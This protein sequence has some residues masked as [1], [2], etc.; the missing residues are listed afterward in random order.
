MDLFLEELNNGIALNDYCVTLNDMIF[1]V[2][3]GFIPLCDSF[4]F[5]NNC[6][7]ELFNLSNLLVNIS[8]MTL[9]YAGQLVHTVVL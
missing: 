1:S 2:N 9:G 3:N 6:S 4:I 5:S 7:L 8:M